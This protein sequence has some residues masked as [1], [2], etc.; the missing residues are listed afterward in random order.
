MWK[1]T[2]T[3]KALMVNYPY[4][5]QENKNSSEVVIPVK[6]FD[7]MSSITW[8]LSEYDAEN[9]IAFWYVTGFYEDEWWSVSLDELESLKFWPMQ[10]IERDEWFKG[11]TFSKLPFHKDNS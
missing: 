6:L 11:T 2:E 4:R 5:S 3:V 9:R 8:W 10:R 1:L 7:T